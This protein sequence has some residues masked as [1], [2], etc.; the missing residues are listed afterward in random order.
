LEEVK[1]SEA[2]I[3]TSR[4]QFSWQTMNCPHTAENAFLSVISC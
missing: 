2:D 1:S 4:H 3:E